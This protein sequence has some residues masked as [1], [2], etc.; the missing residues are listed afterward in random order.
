MTRH[1]NIRKAGAIFLLFVFVFAAT[2]KLYLHDLVSDHTH[3]TTDIK[4]G[5]T[6]SAKGYNCQLDD[7]VVNSGFLND[8]SFIN[9]N[10]YQHLK[11]FNESDAAS[12]Y[13]PTFYHY[14]LRGPPAF[15]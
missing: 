13:R 2:P 15:V 3:I 7:L 12:N 14:S 5:T 8:F 9:I 11:C 1:L 4:Y 6:V 10:N